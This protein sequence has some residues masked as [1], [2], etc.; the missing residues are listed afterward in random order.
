M[1][2]SAQSEHPPPTPYEDLQAT[3]E[4]GQ[5]RRTFRRFVFPVTAF[6]LSW[7]AA[8]VLLSVYAPGFM[9]TR[10]F[11]QVNIGL[12]MGLGQFVTTFAITFLYVRWAK[13]DFDPLADELGARLDG[14]HHIDAD[15]PQ[16]EVEVVEVV[17]DVEIDPKEQR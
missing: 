1:S 6:F 7:Y 4:F 9:S 16:G 8:F 5:L 17:E 10:V 2:T 13:R 14:E 3:P 12:L 15:D 11:G